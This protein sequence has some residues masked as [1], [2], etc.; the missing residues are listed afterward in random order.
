VL[1]EEQ[2][3]HSGAGEKID[4]VL[5]GGELQ[6]NSKMCK[7]I[8]QNYQRS[9]KNKSLKKGPFSP[10]EDAIIIVRVSAWDKKKTGLWI[11]LE[12]EL[13]RSGANICSRWRKVLS[14]R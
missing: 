10:Q 2:Q 13:G 9:L 5:I 8:W 12:R 1:V 6:R 7:R 11:G 3:A 4:W 14:K